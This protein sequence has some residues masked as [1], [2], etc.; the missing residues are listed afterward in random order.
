MTGAGNWTYF[1]PGRHPL[2]ID[3]G[4]GESGHI[5]SI[6]NACE[7]GPRHVVVTHAHGDHISGVSA[8]ADRWPATMFSKYP[9]PERDARYAVQFAAIRDDQ[10]IPAGDSSV[11]AIH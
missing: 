6:E 8:I 9:W 7:D 3:A 4:V 5:A 2:L 11:Q 1:L 10:V